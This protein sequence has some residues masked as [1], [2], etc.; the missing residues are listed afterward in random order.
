MCACEKRRVSGIMKK[1]IFVYNEG[2][3]KKKQKKMCDVCGGSGQTSFFKGVSRF[4]L[5]VEECAECAGTGY[6]LSVVIDETKNNQA[7]K[8]KKRGLKK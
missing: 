7:G 4:L 6:E 1:I 3:A 5:S 8:R 2:M